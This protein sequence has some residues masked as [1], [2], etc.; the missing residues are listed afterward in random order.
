MNFSTDPVFQTFNAF[1]VNLMI[2]KV[3]KL[4]KEGNSKKVAKLLESLSFAISVPNSGHDLRKIAE[5]KEEV[6]EI[7]KETN[8][9]VPSSPN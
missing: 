6:Q 3:Y 8:S 4:A 7:L 9:N 1:S 5:I 2:E